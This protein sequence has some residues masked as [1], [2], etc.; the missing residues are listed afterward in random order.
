M[1]RKLLE[2]TKNSRDMSPMIRFAGSY[3]HKPDTGIITDLGDALFDR[4]KR[5]LL[6]GTKIRPPLF[7]GSFRSPS[8]SG[9]RS[10]NAKN[11]L[12]GQT[13]LG[14]LGLFTHDLVNY[15]LRLLYPLIAGRPDDKLNE[16]P[17]AILE[18]AH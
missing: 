6:A 8:R 10:I 17:L 16:N 11:Y 13:L 14:G 9:Y 4:L 12:R 7:L 5:L 2:S 15:R 3:I 1:S 18:H